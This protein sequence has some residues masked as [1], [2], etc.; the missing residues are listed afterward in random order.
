VALKEM[1]HENITEIA[2]KW[3]KTGR[4]LARSCYQGRYEVYRPK[5]N[6]Y[7]VDYYRKYNNNESKPYPVVIYDESVSKDSKFPDH[8]LLAVD[9]V[10]Y[11]GVIESIESHL[12]TYK[13]QIAYLV[14]NDVT[15][16]PGTYYYF[17][18]NGICTVYYEGNQMKLN[19][20]P[21]GN[22][23]AYIHNVLPS[24]IFPEG[25]VTWTHGGIRYHTL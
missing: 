19:N 22:D 7:D 1:E 2:G 12:K 20:K 8:A 5:L 4:M 21:R 13:K 18:R 14:Y 3:K 23:N 10:Y 9:C 15:R 24:D 11:P 6:D 25:H 16:K 17:D